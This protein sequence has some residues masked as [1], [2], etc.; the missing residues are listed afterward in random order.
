VL[1]KAQPVDNQVARVDETVDLVQVGHVQTEVGNVLAGRVQAPSLLQR[2]AAID[3]RSRPQGL[4]IVDD[5]QL[6]Q[7]AA[8]HAG[9]NVIRSNE[10]YE[11]ADVAGFRQR[12]RQRRGWHA[13]KKPHEFR[14]AF[15]AL[16]G[17]NEGAGLGQMDLRLW[18]DPGRACRVVLRGGRTAS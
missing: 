4:R 11:F 13:W 10:S 3:H 16:A 6:G 8:P 1:R 12:R 9:F 7:R 14:T 15:R 2:Q 17:R 18:G 5:R